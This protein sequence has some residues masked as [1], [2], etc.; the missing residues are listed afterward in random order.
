MNRSAVGSRTTTGMVMQ[1]RVV[2]ARSVDVST[3]PE[4]LVLP[5]EPALPPA[6]VTRQLSLNEAESATVLVDGH[7]G[8]GHRAHMPANLKIAC[9][10]PN[11]VP[12]GP[13]MAM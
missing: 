10:D 11:A 5:Q 8:H 12:F 4:A 7:P 6:T 3:P 9:D 2:S 13:T 1:F